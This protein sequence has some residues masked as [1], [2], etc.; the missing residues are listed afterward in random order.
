[1]TAPVTAR[2]M[3]FKLTPVHQKWASE[4]L[5]MKEATPGNLA[6]A[7]ESSDFSLAEREQLALRVLT[8]PSTRRFAM[9]DAAV[10]TNAEERLLRIKIDEFGQKFFRIEVERRAELHAKLVQRTKQFPALQA[11]LKRLAEALDLKPTELRLKD[12][13]ER[14]LAELALKSFVSW[15]ADAARLRQAYAKEHAEIDAVVK[16]LAKSA[17]AIAALIP[18]LLPEP[19]GRNWWGRRQKPSAPKSRK[20]AV[21]TVQDEGTKNPYWFGLLIL[22]FFLVRVGYRASQLPPVRNVFQNSNGTPVQFPQN[23][24]GVRIEDVLKKAR[25]IQPPDLKLTPIEPL[26]PITTPMP[27]FTPFQ[28]QFPNSPIFRPL[29]PGETG[30]GMPPRSVPTPNAPQS[31]PGN[32]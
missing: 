6:A 26:P 28:K 31:L 23:P 5:D 20:F 14:Q 32:R 24:T 8:A 10:L 12:A 18:E 25:A 9:A 21:K 15:P 2:T 11:Q 30:P 19:T 7:V 16:R 3:P 22:L 17:P 1:M 4:W 13:D 29:Q 27:D